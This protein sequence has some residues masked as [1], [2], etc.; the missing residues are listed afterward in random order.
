MDQKTHMRRSRP[1]YDNNSFVKS[2]SLRK[3]SCIVNLL[4]G[5]NIT[6]SWAGS[7][8]RIVHPCSICCAF[9]VWRLDISCKCAYSLFSMF[10]LCTSPCISYKRPQFYMATWRKIKTIASAINRYF[11]CKWYTNT[12]VI[13]TQ[14]A[15]AIST[16][17]NGCYGDYLQNAR[18][19]R[20]VG[21]DQRVIAFGCKTIFGWVAYPLPA[22]CA[23]PY[24]LA[25]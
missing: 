5:P 7:V 17:M 25:V 6:C 9:H 13:G 18:S 10:C 22:Y 12:V 21:K 20:S 16:R 1:A 2:P 4:R 15:Y 14:R 24:F 11:V 19:F 23:Q 3:A 8:P